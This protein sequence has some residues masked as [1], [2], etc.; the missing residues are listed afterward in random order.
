MKTKEFKQ[1]MIEKAS[2]DLLIEFLGQDFVDMNNKEL[3]ESVDNVLAQMPDEEYQK[4]VRI[5]PIDIE[6][7]GQQWER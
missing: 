6:T 3:E 7:K 1:L 4:F 5:L 2:S